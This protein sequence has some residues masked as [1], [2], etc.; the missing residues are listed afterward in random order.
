MLRG[1][2]RGV[3]GCFRGVRGGGNGIIRVLQMC[4]RG[5][6]GSYRNVKGVTGCHN[7]CERSR[8]LPVN[9]IGVLRKHLRVATAVE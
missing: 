9:V 5:V 1:C 6:T 4:Y 2:Y 7:V 3:T 8:L